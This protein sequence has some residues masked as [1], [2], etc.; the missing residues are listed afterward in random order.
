[1]SKIVVTSDQ[2]L[3]YEHSN[4]SDFLNF[5]DFILER[6]DVQALVLL[7]DMVDMWRRDA[8]GVFLC[9]SEII[10][11]LLDLKYSKKIDI[12]IVAGNHDYHLLKL[13]GQDYK[14]HFYQ[15]LPSATFS[16]TKT[17]G[18]K[19]YTFKHGW[20]FDLAQHPLV[21]ESMCHNMS[22]DAGHARSSIY[23]ILQIAKDQFDKGLKEIIGFHNQRNGYVQNL[24]LSPWKYA[25]I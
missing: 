4:V 15:E 10:K 16:I 17:S 5:L 18:N 12:F 23:N 1:M 7:G 14:F 8:S 9:F 20:E 25:F 2:H 19:K 11:K 6:N 13:G 3:G 22:D 24:M 21:M